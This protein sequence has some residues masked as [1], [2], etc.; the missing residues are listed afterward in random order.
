MEPSNFL[1][2]PWNS[3]YGNAETETI[4]HNIMAILSRTGDTFR[5]ISWSEYKA[6]RLKDVDFSEAEKGYF[7]EVISYCLS[8]ERAASFSPTWASQ[9]GKE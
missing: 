1:T 4:A 6:E 8:A 3:V 2:H 9:V 5:L 7:E